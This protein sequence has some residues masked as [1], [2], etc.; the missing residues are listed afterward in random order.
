MLDVLTVF[1]SARPSGDG[2]MAKCPAHEDRTAS[3]SISAG[4]DGRVLLNCHAGCELDA[5]L[6]AVHLERR[7]LFPQNGNGY[8]EARRIVKTYN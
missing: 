7:D 8:G 4:D 1:P 6:R 3:L 5:I 2:H